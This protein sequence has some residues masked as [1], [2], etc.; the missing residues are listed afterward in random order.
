MYLLY[1]ILYLNCAFNIWYK[2]YVCV[3]YPTEILMQLFIFSAWDS[4]WPFSVLKPSWPLWFWC[5]DEIL[6]LAVNLVVPNHSKPFR[7]ESLSFSGS[8]TSSSRLLKLMK[9]S[10]QDSKLTT[11]HDK[12]LTYKILQITKKEIVNYN[13]T[14][15]YMFY[16]Y[17]YSKIKCYFVVQFPLPSLEWVQNTTLYIKRHTELII[18]CYLQYY[19]IWFFRLYWKKQYW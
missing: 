3:I 2:L 11:T 8:F 7:L 18:F 14:Y 12:M 9:S 6:L 17:V 4:L 5:S 10:N 19:F 13:N 15:T 16:A 1:I